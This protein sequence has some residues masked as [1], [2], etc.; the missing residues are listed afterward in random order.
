MY[1][2][3]LLFFFKKEVCFDFNSEYNLKTNDSQIKIGG[4]VK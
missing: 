2:F 1:L 3:G 4:I